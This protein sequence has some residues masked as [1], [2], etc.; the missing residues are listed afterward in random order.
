V[1]TL[2]TILDRSLKTL[3]HAPS[4]YTEQKETVGRLMRVN[5][6]GEVAAQGLYLGAW[7]A[8]NNPSFKAFCI[9]SMQEESLHLD[10]CLERMQAY[11]TSPSKMNAP[12]YFTAF[13]LGFTSALAGQSYALGFVEET[14]K[15]VLDHLTNHQDLIPKTDTKTH[16][17]ISQMLIDEASHQ[18]HAQ[19]MGAKPLP[20]LCQDL[21]SVMG[22]ALTTISYWV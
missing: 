5:Y 15:Q 3:F 14:E 2:I 11:Q 8:S 17:V 4:Y 21:M 16:E 20:S 19:E 22:K 6:A 12:I 1:D 10:W 18:K 7:L 9:Q 13:G